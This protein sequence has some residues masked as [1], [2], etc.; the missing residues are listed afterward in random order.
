MQANRNRDIS[1]A[2]I[3][4][5]IV[6]FNRLDMSFILLRSIDGNTTSRREDMVLFRMC[7]SIEGIRDPLFTAVYPQTIPIT[8]AGKNC[9]IF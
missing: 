9:M 2:I 5:G 3:I 4:I 1:P 7:S 8:A 6:I